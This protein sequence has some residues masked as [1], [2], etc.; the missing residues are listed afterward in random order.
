MM[1]SQ[2]LG[3]IIKI[4]NKTLVYFLQNLLA[5]KGW[6]GKKTSVE[7]HRNT[8]IKITRLNSFLVKRSLLLYFSS[9]QFVYACYTICLGI[10]AQTLVSKFPN[11]IT[12]IGTYTYIIII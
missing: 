1:F 12:I 7:W 4:K 10:S 5:C 3:L 9:L 2:C 8:C 6:Q 11:D